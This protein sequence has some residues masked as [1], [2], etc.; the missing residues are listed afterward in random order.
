MK[1]LSIEIR[2]D[3]ETGQ[4]GTAWKTNGYSRESIT[5]IFELIGMVENFKGLLTEKVKTLA[6]K[7][8]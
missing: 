4:V 7:Q 8:L 2:I 1:K 5:D 6:S 3:E